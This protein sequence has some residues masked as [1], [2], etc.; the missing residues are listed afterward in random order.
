MINTP[1]PPSRSSGQVRPHLSRSAGGVGGLDAPL[2]ILTKLRNPPPPPEPNMDAAARLKRWSRQAAAKDIVKGRLNLCCRTVLP[3]KKN[4]DVWESKKHTFS[5]GGLIVCGSVWVCPVC[6]TKI[7]EKRRHELAQAMATTKVQGGSALLLTLTVPHYG[8]HRIKNTLD[9]LTDAYRRFTNRKPFKRAAGLL[10]V[11]GR[12]KTTEVTYGP[13][14][15][16]PHLHVLLFINAPVTPGTLRLV[17]ADLLDQWKSACVSA[18]LPEP[19][20]HGLSLDDGSKAAQYVSKWGMENEMTKGHLKTARTN[21]HLS[22]FGLLDLHVDRSSA[23]SDF[24]RDIAPQAGALFYMYAKAFKGK[25]QLVWSRGLRSRLGLGQEK[26]DEE[27]AAAQDQDA[28]LFAQIPL[29]M[30]AVILQANKRGEVLEVCKQGVPAFMRYCKEL[31]EN[32]TGEALAG[33]EAKGFKRSAGPTARRTEGANGDRGKP[34]T[35][36]QNR[37]DETGCAYPLR[38]GQTVSAPTREPTQ[39]PHDYP[40]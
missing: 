23:S 35:L 33:I 20:K 31:C 40:F 22:P 39:A 32:A 26:T 12:V 9:G 3:D 5:Y 6:A 28:D 14:G 13:N 7:T 24:Q 11:F 38:Y 10:G 29:E 8:H 27:L 1:V 30:W 4:V 25:Q 36:E 17:K 37:R 34:L 16:H 18:G 15:W 21:D 19:N 2:G